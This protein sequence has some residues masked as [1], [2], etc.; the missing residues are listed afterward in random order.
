MFVFCYEQRVHD[1]IWQIWVAFCERN[2]KIS[3][4]TKEKQQYLW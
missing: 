3:N 1:Q 4:E 2:A